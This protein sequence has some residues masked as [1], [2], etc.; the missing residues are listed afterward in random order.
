M[1]QQIGI[2]RRGDGQELDPIDGV[3]PILK[4]V[5]RGYLKVVG[6]GF[7][8]TRYGLFMTARHVLDDIVVEGPEGEIELGTGYLLHQMDEGRLNLRRIR[9]CSLFNGAD[10]AIGQAENYLEK[11]RAGPLMNFRGKLTTSIPEDG[12]ELITYAYPENDVIDFTTENGNRTIVGDY[13]RGHFLNTVPGVERSPMPYLHFDTSLQVKSGASGGPVFN[14]SGRIVGV[15]CRGWD[16]GGAEYVGDDLSSITPI[17]H[18]MEI[19]IPQSQVPHGSWEMRQIPADK[20]VSAMTF[21]DLINYGHIL[22][23]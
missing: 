4:E 8:I 14:D 2:T 17:F 5:S 10:L 16:F 6:T 11:L 7:Y 9:S 3:V 15:N 19:E 23:Q 20:T 18:A 21:R 22:L 13:F 1:E 12:A